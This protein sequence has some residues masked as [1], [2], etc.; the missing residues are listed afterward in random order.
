M[1]STSGVSTDARPRKVC[2]ETSQPRQNAVIK[3]NDLR[4]VHLLHGCILTALIFC[5]SQL[6]CTGADSDT[7]KLEMATDTV[8]NN[9]DTI[10]VQTLLVTP[11][12]WPTI[13]RSQGS[14]IAD[15]VTVVSTKVAG[16]V[17]RVNVDLGD[18]VDASQPLVL[19]DTAEFEL[20]VNQAK[21]RLHQALAAVGLNPN[22]ST[23]GLNPNHAPPVRQEKAVWDEAQNSLRRTETLLKQ[24]AISKGEYDLA[25][26]AE[27]SAEARH[28]AALNAV[29]EKIAMIN[30]AQTEL[31]LTEH[32]IE[33]ATILAP[34]SGYI[35]R[36]NVAPGTYLSIGE[37]VVTLVRT[38]PLR[39]SG[40]LPERYAQLVHVGLTVNLQLASMPLPITATISRVSPALNDQSRSLDFEAD[41]SNPN[42]SIRAGLFAEAEVVV[43]PDAEAIAVPIT[44]V[45]SFAGVQKVWKVISNQAV[46]QEVLLGA[47]RNGWCEVTS[48]IQ[49]GDEI[50]LLASK[51]KQAKV[52]RSDAALPTDLWLEKSLNPSSTGEAK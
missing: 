41:L 7:P 47:K 45:D 51:G 20:R 50:L 2:H 40:S 46:E 27:R 3:P 16:R 49:F 17:A 26:A 36:R 32:Q 44:A 42:Q 12:N 34:F 28:A 31:A 21:A 19:I 14:L 9:Q 5:S 35:R 52:R 29:Q 4:D 18:Q 33:E 38:D 39:F 6:G 1:P 30:T 25:F 8:T 15:E 23:E 22:D 43:D 11:T 13:V 10:E 24:G 48:G 37:P